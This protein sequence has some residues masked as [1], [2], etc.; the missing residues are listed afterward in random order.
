MIALAAA[1][2][3]ETRPAPAREAHGVY[4][5]DKQIGTAAVDKLDEAH[6]TIVFRDM[7]LSEAADPA[8][9]RAFR[10]VLLQCKSVALRAAHHS[11]QRSIMIAG[12]YCRIVATH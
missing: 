1:L 10:N 9:P 11:A 5:G 3:S 8:V 6:H 4:Q 2:K 7:K 12:E